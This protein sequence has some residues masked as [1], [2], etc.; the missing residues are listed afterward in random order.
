MVI[1]AFA[2]SDIL[3]TPRVILDPSRIAAQVVSGIGFLGAGSILIRGEVVRGLTTAASLWAVA[4]IGLAVGCGLCVEAR[5]AWDQERVGARNR[6]IELTSQQPRAPEA[7][8]Y[9]GVSVYYRV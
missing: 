7:R 1:S 2:F 6:L 8:P 9:P 4:A 3:G 5:T